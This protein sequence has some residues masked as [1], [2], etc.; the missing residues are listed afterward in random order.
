MTLH[1]MNFPEQPHNI[2]GES[3]LIG[4]L[5]RDNKL[6]DRVADIIRHEDF[7]EPLYGRIYSVI[8][9]CVSKGQQ[10][11]PVTLKP[12]F[13]HDEAL[14][15]LGGM[16]FLVRLTGD[17]A[18]IAPAK[19][20]ARQIADMAKRRRMI[21]GLS[22]TIT[23]AHD[24]AEI[25]QIIDAADAVIVEAAS[26]GDELY[27]PTGAQCIGDYLHDVENHKGGVLNGR[28]PEL[29]ELTGGLR[30]KQ[31]V[32]LA[33]RPGMGKTSVA[34]SYSLGAAINGHGV[35]FISLEMSSSELAARML[36]DLSCTN[37]G[38]MASGIPYSRL[39]SGDL[40]SG[41]RRD[42]KGIQEGLS[43]LPFRVIDTGRLTIGR[44]AMIVRRYVRRMEAQGT[45]LSLVVVDY[46][47]LLSTD[48]RS[49]SA[50]EG[51]SEISKALKQIA[52]DNDVAVLALAQLSR[53]VEKRN[54]K[55]PMLSDLRDSGQIEQDA[56]TVMFLLREEYYL[57][58]EDERFM[59]ADELDRHRVAVEQTRDRI[60]FICAK[61]RNGLT[62]SA[63]GRFFGQFQAVRGA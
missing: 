52:K 38:P 6:V 53:E 56:D 37:Q 18:I 17:V 42:I 22:D 47:Q 57:K 43:E 29:D 19:E 60:E 7:F 35:L 49:R 26:E 41:D 23:L 25:A 59:K 58:Q 45:P 61:R 39:I 31:M 51:V 50:Y 9:D 5:L 44:L 15:R 16:G 1:A 20:I 8:L 21:D 54:D 46:L 28:I 33:G 63:T 3:A 36:S 62:G 4:A 34:L 11:S 27:Q 10:V 48:Q 13:E 55:R 40:T 12:Y 32:I 30:G 24:N 2:E 14:S